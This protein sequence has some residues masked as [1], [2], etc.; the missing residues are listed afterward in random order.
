MIDSLSRNSKITTWQRIKEDDEEIKK[1]KNYKT[2][3]F[4]SEKQKKVE[5]KKSFSF[6]IDHN[7]A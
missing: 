2:C 7:A 4:G 6:F 1:K 5:K 3:D